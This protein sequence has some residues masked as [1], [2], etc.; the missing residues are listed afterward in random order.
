ML[1]KALTARGSSALAKIFSNS[2]QIFLNRRPFLPSTKDDPHFENSE[3]GGR[4]RLSRNIRYLVQIP[5][6]DYKVCS[7]SEAE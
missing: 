1:P 2:P 4:F 6:L 5:I 7:A 3:I